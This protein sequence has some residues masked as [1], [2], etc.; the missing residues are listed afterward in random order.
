MKEIT[1]IKEIQQI[2]LKVLDYIVS[3]CKQNKLRYYLIGG[4]L[5]GA[6]RHKGFIPW[7]DDIDI[8]MPRPDYDKL[9][10]IMKTDPDKR[11]KLF[12]IEDDNDYPH[13]FMKV[14]DTYTEIKEKYRQLDITGLGV[15]VDI[16]PMD[17][18]MS[19]MDKAAKFHQNAYIWAGTIGHALPKYEE[20]NILQKIQ[21][22][23]LVLLFYKHRRRKFERIEAR[24]KNYPFD[25]CEY[26]VSTFG[27]RGKNEIL[28][29]ENFDSCMEVP[30]ED[31]KYIIPVGYDTYLRNMYN[32]YMQLPPEDQRCSPHSL[33][34]Y[35]KDNN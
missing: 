1:D 28:K 29:R 35:W 19:D 15:F 32:D 18:I 16:F 5:L 2:E 11:Y 24:Y 14:S 10:D 26:V 21:R 30:F 4:T 23:I 9:A 20:M 3:L 12:R 8:T 34:I 31:R 27:I 22:F 13:G 17:G 33:K 7:D 25:E 6:I